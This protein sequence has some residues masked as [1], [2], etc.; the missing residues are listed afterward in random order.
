MTTH[1]Y[2]SYRNYKEGELAGAAADLAAQL[3]R[4]FPRCSATWLHMAPHHSELHD[5]GF[6]SW[7]LYSDTPPLT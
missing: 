5:L 4:Q 7:K 3:E 2:G 1:Q 6:I